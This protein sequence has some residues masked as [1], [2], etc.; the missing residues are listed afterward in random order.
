M[1]TLRN[2]DAPEF[3]SDVYAGRSIAIFSHFGRWH[4]YLDHIFQY[5]VVFATTE[6]AVM[7]LTERID[8]GI[9]ARLN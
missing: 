6:D 7:W 1:Q 5:D 2:S 4:V 9:P 8:Q 3:W